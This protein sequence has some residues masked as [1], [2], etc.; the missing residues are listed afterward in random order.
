MEDPYVLSLCHEYLHV[1]AAMAAGVS[2]A[3][4]KELSSQRTWT[5]EELIR[6]TGLDR[7]F[8]MQ[9]YARRCVNEGV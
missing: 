1:C 4:Y 7:P 3:D 9:A 2:D 5:H 8:D 6:L